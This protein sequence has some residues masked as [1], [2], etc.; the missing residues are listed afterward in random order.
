MVSGSCD[1]GSSWV[2]VSNNEGKKDNK[3]NRNSNGSILIHTFGLVDDSA[4]A[5]L[6]LAA[7]A[8]AGAGSE[9]DDDDGAADMVAALASSVVFFCCFDAIFFF[10][11]VCDNVCLLSS[12]A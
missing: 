10:E 8:G 7:G 9:D 6:V 11:S 4:E 1:D 2:L 3:R 12:N 5:P